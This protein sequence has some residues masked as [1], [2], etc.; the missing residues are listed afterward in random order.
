MKKK[1]DKSTCFVVCAIILLVLCSAACLIWA[2]CMSSNAASIAGGVLSVAA[3]TLLGVI[4]VWQNR[5]Y[6]ELA[7]EKSRQAEELM[8]TPECRLF[9]VCNNSQFSVHKQIAIVEEGRS[10]NYYLHFFS[11]NHTMIDITV[12]EISYW[13]KANNRHILR[14]PHNKI[15]F[16]NIHFTMFGEHNDFE[17]NINIP[18]EFLGVDIICR[19]TLEYKNIYDSVVHKTVEFER[20]PNGHTRITKQE[21]AILIGKNVEDTNHADA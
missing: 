14:Y 2:N 19:V 16:S 5:K 13:E 17:I 6:K 4:A 3:T 11:L 8:F 12:E 9:D 20:S 18:A 10:Q 15:L 7:D 1:T 21:R